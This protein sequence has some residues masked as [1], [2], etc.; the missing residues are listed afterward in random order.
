M[1]A[2]AIPEIPAPMM[3]TRLVIGFSIIYSLL[4]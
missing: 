3:A 1:L 4:A 2:V